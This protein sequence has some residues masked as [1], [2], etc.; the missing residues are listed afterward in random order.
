MGGPSGPGERPAAVWNLTRAGRGV[1]PASQ[2]SASALPAPSQARPGTVP[3]LWPCFAGSLLAPSCPDPGPGSAGALSPPQK[4]NRR[5]APPSLGGGGGGVGVG[6][7]LLPPAHWLIVSPA[8][9]LF[10][11]RHTPPLLSIPGF[12]GHLPQPHL[13]SASGDLQS[14]LNSGPDARA[15]CKPCPIPRRPTLKLDR[16][17]TAKEKGCLRSSLTSSGHPRQD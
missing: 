17:H 6:L 5:S 14:F 15:W 1:S 12:P 10:L 4:H 13:L 9:L 7:W 16:S 3:G 2:P 11:R 8:P